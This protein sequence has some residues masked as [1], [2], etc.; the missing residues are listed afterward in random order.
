MVS[1]NL[2]TEHADRFRCARVLRFE[3]E[4]IAHIGACLGNAEQPGLEIDHRVK[5]LRRQAF[6]AGEIP[7]KAGIEVA[8]A[9]AHR[10]A[11]ARL[12]RHAG[13]DGLAIANGRKAGTIA[14]IAHH[15]PAGCRRLSREPRQLAGEIGVG[16]AVKTVA[17]QPLRLVAP[18]DR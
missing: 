9:G 3:R 2:V 7:A 16:Q 11:S 5:L 4:Q 6:G 8:A 12:Q 1:F 18:R 15:N 14:Q 13:I 17:A 10:N